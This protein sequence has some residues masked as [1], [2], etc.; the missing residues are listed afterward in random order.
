MRRVML[1]TAFLTLASG[2]TRAQYNPAPHLVVRSG[3]QVVMYR[4][5]SLNPDCTS[6]GY[7]TVNL[8]EAP[9]GGEALVA[10]KRDYVAFWP[11][12]PR[13]ACNK[14]KV[15]ATEIIYKASPG[16]V[17]ND[18]FKA[19]IIDSEGVSRTRIFRVEVR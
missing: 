7:A 18:A 10:D 16:F 13:S 2:S 12:N 6:R 5:T 9:R 17:G 4:L 14:R 19:E 1:I 3:G 15:P 11:G 8:L